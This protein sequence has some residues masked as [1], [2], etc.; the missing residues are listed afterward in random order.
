MAPEKWRADEKNFLSSSD[1]SDKKKR[2]DKR[3]IRFHFRLEIETPTTQKRMERSCWNS[4]N[5]W[6]WERIEFKGEKWNWKQGNPFDS[7]TFLTLSSLF[8]F[9]YFWESL[10][11]IVWRMW[12][13]VKNCEECE[14]QKWW[15]EIRERERVEKRGRNDQFLGHFSCQKYTSFAFSHFSHSNVCIF[16][17]SLSLRFNSRM[18]IKVQNRE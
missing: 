1:F 13:I 2:E 17:D 4:W 10:S 14:Q 6:R 15:Q 11:H 16:N 9:S 18:R 12:R 3:N 8:Y 5:S 7:Y